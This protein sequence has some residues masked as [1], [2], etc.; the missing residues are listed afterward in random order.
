MTG[1]IIW[2]SHLQLRVLAESSLLIQAKFICSK[3][4]K[5]LIKV[6]GSAAVSFAE[7]IHIGV[8]LRQ[9]SKRRVSQDW[10]QILKKNRVINGNKA[11]FQVSKDL[12]N[13]QRQT[14]GYKHRQ[15]CARAES[16]VKSGFTSEIFRRDYII[17]HEVEPNPSLSKDISISFNV[18]WNVTSCRQ[19][20]HQQ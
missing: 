5:R 12:W 15:N 11:G 1:S 2:N 16:I 7:N 10:Q 18:N 17:A 13:F 14:F 4:I 19:K 9:K 8:S 20:R 3:Q 6:K